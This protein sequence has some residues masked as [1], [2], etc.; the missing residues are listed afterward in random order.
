[1]DER[2]QLEQAITAPSRQRERLPIYINSP[3]LE[4]S[5]YMYIFLSP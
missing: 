2:E 3:P 1:M 5:S 4:F